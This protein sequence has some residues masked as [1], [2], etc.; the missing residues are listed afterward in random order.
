MLPQETTEEVD[1]REYV[2]ILR[3]RKWT[4][5]FTTLTVVVSALAV[6][7]LQQ[8]LY[9]GAAKVLLQP[10]Q[11]ATLFNPQTGQRGDPVRAVQTEIEILESEPVQAAVREALGTVP[12]VDAAPVGQTDVIEVRAHSADPERAA[13]IANAYAEAYIAF[14]RTTAVE[15]LLAAGREIEAKLAD[16]QA[17]VAAYEARIAAAG[18]T[19]AAEQLRAERNSLIQQQALFNQKLDQLQVEASL[20]SGGASLV[21]PATATDDPVSPQPLRNGVLAAMLGVLLGVGLAFLR[22]QLDDTIK[23]KDDLERFVPHLP[24]LAMI[25]VQAGWRDSAEAQLVTVTSPNSSAAEAYR[26]LRTSIH[27]R[28][29][30]SPL[31]SIQ[32]TSASAQEG[33]TTTLSNLAVSL[34]TAGQRVAV[35]CCYLRRPRVHEFFGLSNEVGFT[36]AILGDVPLQD[37]LQ[38]V[39]GIDRLI[40]LASGPPPPNPSELLGGHHTADVLNALEA[41]VDVVLIDSPPVLPV[42]D[43]AVLAGRVDGTI[44]VVSAGQTTKRHVTRAVEILGHVEAPLLGIVLNGVAPDAAYGYGY[45]YGYHATADVANPD[46]RPADGKRRF[47]RPK[48]VAV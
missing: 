38:E 26:T 30:D 15:S 22:E 18:V 42:T 7:F 34:S 39:P 33:K 20:R 13:R 31:R 17:Q 5:L 37:A 14:K 44:L 16:L 36:S 29:L 2:A 41:S 45:G 32:V 23:G 8:P 48:S 43:S 40:L 25:P 6:S 12:E 35:V 10:E 24:I 3:R 1:L 47:R 27:F 9:E 11:A 46:K 28:S 4:I 21:T 19:D